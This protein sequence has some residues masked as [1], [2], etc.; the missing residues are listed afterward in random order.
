[1]LFHVI[2]S[3]TSPAD[4]HDTTT[5]EWSQSHSHSQSHSA[6]TSAT[7]SHSKRRRP[8]GGSSSSNG[9]HHQQQQVPC[10]PA[11]AKGYHLPPREDAVVTSL[12]ELSGSP[13]ASP[14]KQAAHYG[15]RGSTS[16]STGSG[17]TPLKTGRNGKVS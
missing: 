4:G 9:H 1:M 3:L 6:S 13:S 10:S 17:R 12:M 8:N 7:R 11:A 2:R 14:V 15:T 5:H 16:S